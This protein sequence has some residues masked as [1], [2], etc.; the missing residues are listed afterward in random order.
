MLNRTYE[1]I[2][3]R[4]GANLSNTLKYKCNA[5]GYSADV[6]DTQVETFFA[7]VET[8]HCLDCKSLVEVPVKFK[9]EAYIGGDADFKMN[10][11]ENK[12]PEC[13]GTNVQPWDAKHP[14]PKC[15]EHMTRIAQG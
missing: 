2:S 13:F 5:C 1:L 7:Y 14:C 6:H 12:C 10:P 3:S 9:A 8:K 4:L 11:V 15:G